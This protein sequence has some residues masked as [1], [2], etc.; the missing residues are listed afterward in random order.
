M[1]IGH[2]D[3]VEPYADRLIREA[4]ESGAFEN[5]TGEGKPIPGSGTTDDDLWW[6]RSWVER[7]LE[8]DDQDSRSSS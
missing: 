5:L 3:S 8:P 1:P 7:N 4:M 6:I 2:P